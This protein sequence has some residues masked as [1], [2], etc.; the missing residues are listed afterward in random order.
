MA[1]FL[2]TRSYLTLIW[3]SH[4][5]QYRQNYFDALEHRR[6]PQ[7]TYWYRVVGLTLRCCGYWNILATDLRHGQKSISHFYVAL[8]TCVLARFSWTAVRAKALQIAKQDEKEPATFPTPYAISSLKRKEDEKIN[9]V[10]GLTAVPSWRRVVHDCL[11]PGDMVVCMHSGS[12]HGAVARVSVSP[13]CIWSCLS[14]AASLFV[15]IIQLL[16]RENLNAATTSH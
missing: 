3:N 11:F 6:K 4:K 8:V 5:F 15:P 1:L 2:E 9:K 14:F 10:S 7:S 16:A 12:Q 13:P